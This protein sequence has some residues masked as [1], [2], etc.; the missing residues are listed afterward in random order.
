MRDNENT[1]GAV[2][3]WALSPLNNAVHLLRSGHPPGALTG[4]CGHLLPAATR[5]HDQP[6]P[7]SPCEPCR[8]ALL[9]DAARSGRSPIEHP[10]FPGDRP[11]SSADDTEGVTD[12]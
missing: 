6:P 3:W 9:S 11:V 4:R 12:L 5:A 1:V 10:P 7:G 2:R 8:L